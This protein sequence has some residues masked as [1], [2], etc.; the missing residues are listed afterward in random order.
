MQHDSDVEMRIPYY[1]YACRLACITPI[2]LYFV[3]Y[4]R[5]IK[6][7]LLSRILF[8]LCTLPL[9]LMTDP[10]MF[11][12][13]PLIYQCSTTRFRICSRLSRAKLQIDMKIRDKFRR[14]SVP[15]YC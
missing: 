1:M 15:Y 8:I 7:V 6:I 9:L 3:Q 4:G 10:I 14:I 13:I 11:M 5:K 2:E 12:V